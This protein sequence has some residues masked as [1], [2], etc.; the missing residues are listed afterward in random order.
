MSSNY[1]VAKLRRSVLHLVGGRAAQALCRMLLVLVVVRL[2]PAEDFGV[3]M[4]AVGVSE[5]LLQTFSLGILPVGQRFLPQIVDTAASTDLRRFIRG[6]SAVQFSV[7]VLVTLAIWSYWDVLL[8]LVGFEA[9]QIERTRPAVWMMLFVPAFRF[10]ADLLEALLEQGKA[11][12]VRA[13][14]PLGRLVGIGV[15]LLIGVQVDLERIL[16]IDSGA[17]VVCLIIAWVFMVGTLRG[18]ASPSAPQPLPVRAMMR[19]AWHMSSVDLLGSASA[20][21]AIRIVIANA[22]SLVDSGLFAFLQSLQR[23]VGRYLPSVLLRGLIRPMMISR[24]GKENGL[25]LMESAAALLQKS[26]LVIIAACAMVVF[27]GGDWIV[28]LASGGRF[29][30]A[31]DT[32]LLMVALVGITSQRLVLEMLMQILNQTHI[33]RATAMLAPLALVLVSLVADYGLNVVCVVSASG[34]ALANVIC[35][36]RLRRITGQ[37]RSGWRDNAR[38]L[39]ATAVA[40]VFGYLVQAAVG[41]WFAMIAASL[42]LVLL[43]AAVKPL[44]SNELRL[45]DRGIGSFSKRV[46]TPFA[47]MAAP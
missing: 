24:L 16:Y 34:V 36:A 23:L 29:P 41:M 44:R 10:V 28:N 21:G 25:Q 40:A 14:M 42:L 6:I 47:R 2:M 3:Y 13:L 11:Q 17:T 7:L 32:L 15:L 5:M 26:N 46:L 39:S 8:P 37:F 1:G 4:L 35:M 38:I 18:I 45:V 33:L 9:E 27:L 22:L 31:G 20:P 30:H 12:S 43:M 19:H